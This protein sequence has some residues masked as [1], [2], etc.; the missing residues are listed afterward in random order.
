MFQWLRELYEIRRDHKELSRVCQSCEVLKVE[1]SKERREK[2]MLLQHVLHPKVEES[3]KPEGE[4]QP[5]RARHTPW[6]VK[7]QE[8]ESQDRQQAQ[9]IMQEFKDRVAPIEKVMGVP[10]GQEKV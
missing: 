1:L 4:P 6:R 9:R 10:D 2:E 3:I 7:Q 5:I 8:L